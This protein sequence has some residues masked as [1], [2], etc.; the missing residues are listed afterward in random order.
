MSAA[1]HLS[2]EQIQGLADGTLRGPEGLEARE[3]VDACAECAAEMSMY[4]ALVQRLQ[5]L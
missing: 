4:G 2:E 1:V 5:T 3:H